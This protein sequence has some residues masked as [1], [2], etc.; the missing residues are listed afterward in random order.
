MMT[1][2]LNGSPRRGGNSVWMAGVFCGAVGGRAEV[3]HLYDEGVM[4]CV[5]CLECA[6]G[7][8]C[9]LPDGMY[10]IM[11]RVAEADCLVLASP[12]HFSSLT[13]PLVGFISRLQPWW[14]GTERLGGGRKRTGVLLVSGGAV[15]D[16]MFR[17]ARSVAAAAFK[18]LGM[19]FA[20]MVGAGGADSLPIDGNRQVVDEIKLL[21]ERATSCSDG[22]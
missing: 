5:A 4:P 12:L 17:P 16:N 6:R 10:G 9:P 11:A 21:A 2:V 14:H 7:R 13:A 22:L 8:R 1:I 18:V 15:Y 3:V 20:G 19:R